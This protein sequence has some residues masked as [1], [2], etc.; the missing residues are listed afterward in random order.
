MRIGLALSGGGIR[1]AAHIGVLKALEEYNMRPDFISG[2]SMGSIVGALYSVGY[3]PNEIE[4]IFLSVGKDIIDFD[5]YGLLKFDLGLIFKKKIQ[6]DGLIKGNKIEK[7]MYGLTK[8]KGIEKIKDTRIPLAISAVDINNSDIVMFA[9]QSVNDRDYVNVKDVDIS[10][11]VR[12]SISLP[13]IFKPKVID[14]KKLVDGGVRE[15]VPSKV[16]KEMGAKSVIAVNLG[17]CGEYKEHINN[18]IEILGQTLDIMAYSIFISE[19]KYIDVLLKPQIYDVKLLEIDKIK[20]CI[21]QG[22]LYTK[23]M[24]PV[25]KRKLVKSA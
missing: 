1:G 16:L 11:A 25:I 5:F 8:A 9:S 18:I 22:Y 17:Y 13:G 4:E 21:D 24:M 23:S 20:Q 14:D 2:A 7:L 3:T 19:E 12:A 6:V 10:C 15:N